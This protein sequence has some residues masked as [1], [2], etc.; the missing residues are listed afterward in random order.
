MKMREIWNELLYSRGLEPNAETFAIVLK[1]WSQQRNNVAMVEEIYNTV[2]LQQSSLNLQRTKEGASNLDAV[3]A[4]DYAFAAVH[5]EAV[6][7]FANAGREEEAL[8][9]LDR[10]ILPRKPNFLDDT[11]LIIANSVQSVMNAYRKK[12]IDP[13]SSGPAKLLALERAEALLRKVD[14]SNVLDAASFGTFDTIVCAYD[15]GQ[16][17]FARPCTL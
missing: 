2:F 5:H 11:T 6:Y 14:L 9:C 12:T 17:R 13:S 8:I 1:Y 15:I 4:S 3:A 16:N 10:M 7:C